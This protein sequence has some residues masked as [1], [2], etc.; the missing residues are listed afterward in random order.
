M[1]HRSVPLVVVL[2]VLVSSVCLGGDWPQWRGPNRD[3]LSSETGLLQQWPEGGPPLLWKAA[4]LGKGFS[5]VAIAGDRIYTTGEKGRSSY[6]HGLA[7]DG[8]KILWTTKIGK[9]GAPGWGGFTGPRSTPT[10][11]G[12]LLFV[13]GQ[14]GELLCLKTADGSAVWSKHMTKDF[15][16]KRPEWGFSESVLVD[17]DQL[18]CTP[19]GKKGAIVALNKRTGDVLWQTK[20]F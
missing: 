2:A 15:G 16:G 12:D 11:D 18:V 19:G 5:T 10:V 17:G 9:A 3:G 14:Y 7:L 20:D 1:S 4:G 8:G 6:V 13:T